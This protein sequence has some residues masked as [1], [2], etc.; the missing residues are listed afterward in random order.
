MS[1]Q[2]AFTVLTVCTGN[3]ARSPLMAGMLA[4]RLGAADVDV[5]S[6]GTVAVV[7]EPMTAEA[8]AVAERYGVDGSAHRSQPLTTELVASA[9]LVLV[10]TR[11]HRADVARLEPIAS[12]RTFTLREFARL[13]R[14]V[15]P[16]AVAEWTTD[17][18]VRGP[19]LV[20]A[21]ASRRGLV[22][23][24]AHPTDD[25]IDDPFLRPVAIYDRVGAEIDDA[26]GT[27]AIMIAA[28]DNARAE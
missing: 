19:E 25:D 15:D 13:A 17:I 1:R 3:I 5:V 11:E 28:P 9:D 20:R 2:A 27:L 4:A 23:P 22:P 21:V 12:R 24:L 14:A 18:A 8:L 10:A 26:V 16:G 7:G 6:A